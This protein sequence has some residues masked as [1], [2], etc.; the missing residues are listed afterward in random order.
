MH[1]RQIEEM[2]LKIPADKQTKAMQ[3]ILKYLQDRF[4]VDQHDGFSVLL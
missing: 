1:W 2:I 3:K 4:V